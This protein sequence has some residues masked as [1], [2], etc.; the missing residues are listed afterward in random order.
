M[1]LSDAQKRAL[2]TMVEFDCPLH[3]ST[4]DGHCW[5]GERALYGCPGRKVR[6][7]TLRALIKRRL[8]VERAGEKGQ[9]YW[10]RDF[11]LTAKGRE[12]AKELEER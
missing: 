10:R 2:T 7:T 9:P 1:K 8:V 6:Y 3:S 4:P 12:V 11:L 5:Y